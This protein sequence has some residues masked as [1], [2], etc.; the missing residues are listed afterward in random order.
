MRRYPAKLLL[1]GEY[2]LLLGAPALALPLPGFG[3]AW[4]WSD[5][6]PPPERA[7][8]MAPALER[9]ARSEA[10]RD[11]EGLDVEAFTRDLGRGLW[12]A[13]NIPS[14]YGLGS[15]GALCAGVFDRYARQRPDDLEAL[16]GVLARMESFFHGQSSGLDPLTSYT[17][18][19]LLL[20]NR[21]TVEYFTGRAWAEPPI[22]FLLDTGLPRQ[23]GPL[24]RWFLDQA[25][26]PP[27][28]RLL[29]ETLLPAHRSML[30][31]WAA[32]D[33]AAFWPALRAYSGF[34]LDHLQPMIPSGIQEVWGKILSEEKIALKLCG[35]GGGGFVLGFARQEADVREMAARHSLIYP[36]D[37]HVPTAG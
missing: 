14:G 3:G 9:W 21:G 26:T 28:R 18:R 30:A 22:V 24:V 35:A 7:R 33:A 37:D 19:A 1:F 23:T 16:K 5:S 13:S 36:L 15:S 2:V 17:G 34:Q 25:A 4:A 12:F 31:A 32:A 27:F 11:V 20:E 10:L 8:A 6:A 29:E